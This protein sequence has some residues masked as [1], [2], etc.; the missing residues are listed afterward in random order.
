MSYPRKSITNNQAVKDRTK[1]D[2]RR[3]MS[4]RHLMTP[5]E[6]AAFLQIEVNTLYVMKSQGRIPF[7]KVGHLLR[8]DFDEII[9]WTKRSKKSDCDVAISQVPSDH[10]C[11]CNR[12]NGGDAL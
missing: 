9:E 2:S 10:L 5:Q 6:C 4:S 8:F 3:S 11:G 7:R 12:R 1:E